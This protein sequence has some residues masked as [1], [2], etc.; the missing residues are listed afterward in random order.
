MKRDSIPDSNDINT[1]HLPL[2]IVLFVLAV[3]VAVS[4][5]TYG[6]KRAGGNEAG[7]S[8]VSARANGDAPRYASRFRLTYNFKGSSKSIRV[9]KNEIADAYSAVL[10]RL[11]MLTDAENDYVGYAGNLCDLNKRVNREV[12][13]PQELFDILCDALS[14]TE[15]GTG[16]SIYDAPLY[17]EWERIAYAADAADFDPLR[18]ADEA[19]RLQAIAAACA[20]R[21]NCRLEIVDA[22][23]CAVQLHVAQSYLDFLQEY[24]LPRTVLSLNRLRDAY[25]L[26]AVADAL[27]EHGYADGFL[28]TVGGLTAALSGNVDGDYVISSYVNHIAAVA[29]TVPISPGAVG[30]ALNAFPSEEGE[31]GFYTVDGMLRCAAR[32]TVGAEDAPIRSVFLL[33][34]SGDIVD[35][36]EAAFR[37]FLL[38]DPE[39]LEIP[40]G[41][42]C[43]FTRSD[44]DG[45]TLY[46]A[47]D[48]IAE[49]TALSGFEIKAYR[50]P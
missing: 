45:R 8:V 21:D 23:R 19:E 40:E 50:A 11:Y 33:R 12:I 29:A 7:Y 25:L 13:V 26:R 2:R 39:Q 15:K 36:C 24:E 27:E 3:I 47:A 34:R 14:R 10:A 42:V 49:I 35:V 43:T 44:G 17:A 6:V 41:D 38:D 18:N 48:G 20:D 4:A 9:L 32:P 1:K 28:Y 37:V 16:Y 22:A 30:C 31:A 46:A 5:I